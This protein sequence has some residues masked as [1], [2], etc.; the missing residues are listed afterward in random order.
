MTKI[1]VK[2]LAW[3]QWNIEHLKKHNVT[4]K[5]V[6][7]SIINFIAHKHGYKGRYILIG[8]SGNRIISTI[9]KREKV[10]TY[11]VITARDAD[12]KERKI[13]YEKENK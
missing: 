11:L 8:R 12:K 9:V 1:R 2:K 5:E 4:V 13:V 10:N 3:R 7:F 6:E